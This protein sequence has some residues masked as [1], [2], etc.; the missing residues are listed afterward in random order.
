MMLVAIFF[1][2]G[3]DA[4]SIVMGA[5][6]QRGT[7]SPRR[8][9]VIFWGVATG[10]VAAIMLLVGDADALTGLQTLTIV[11]ALPFALVMVALS[12][13]LVKD[14]RRDPMMVRRRYA[15]DAVEQAVV[16]GVTKHGDGFAIAVHPS[17]E[18]VLHGGDDHPSKA[19]DVAR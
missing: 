11:A 9:T 1:V 18:S 6:S 2:S 5:L 14:L 7:L 10:G 19:A 4:A 13:A 15:R 8:A 16:E 12:V 17:N 3:A